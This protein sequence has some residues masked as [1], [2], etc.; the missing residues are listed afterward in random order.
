MCWKGE[1][2]HFDPSGPPVLTLPWVGVH[3]LSDT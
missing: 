3:I 2:S 1:F